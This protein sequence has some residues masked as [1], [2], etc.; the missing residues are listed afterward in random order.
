[1]VLNSF[2]DIYLDAQLG[3]NI[4]TESH[5]NSNSNS[6]PLFR[7]FKR[8]FSLKSGVCFMDA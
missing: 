1:M 5:L 3:I 8:I 4:T 6:L 7:C 2:E